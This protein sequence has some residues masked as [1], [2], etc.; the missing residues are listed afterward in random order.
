MKIINESPIAKSI[1]CHLKNCGC[2][3]S[4]FIWYSHK[5]RAV[6]YETPKAACS[7][8]KKALQIKP[9]KENIARAYLLHKIGGGA[10]EM[11]IGIKEKFC[12]K[13]MISEQQN[14]INTKQP[15][16]VTVGDYEFS[17]Y[18]GGFEE[19]L[20]DFSDYYKF[21]FVREP[22]KRAVSNFQMFFNTDD[23]FRFGQ[24]KTLYGKKAETMTFDDFIA[25]LQ[26][27]HNHHWDLYAN[28]IQNSSNLDKLGKLENIKNDWQ[29]ICSALGI[30][31][32]LPHENKSKKRK[33][34]VSKDTEKL[35]KDIYKKDYAEFGY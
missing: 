1:N 14:R 2:R 31:E 5:L 20:V 26:Q 35:I 10:P 34:E 6:Y 22:V 8:I 30:K 18:Y 3:F 16:G 33:V 12:L 25:S 15:S 23:K 17:M 19:S 9:R 4:T 13:E 28:Y 7:S 27:V 32:P 29:E 24:M 21:G 11:K